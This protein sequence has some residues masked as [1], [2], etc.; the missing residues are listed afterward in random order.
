MPAKTLGKTFH[1]SKTNETE[2]NNIYDG[3]LFLHY[4]IIKVYG[5]N[6]KLF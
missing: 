3:W 2:G 6:N 1:P 5:I 4:S